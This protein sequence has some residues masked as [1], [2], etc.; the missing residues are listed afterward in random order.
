M[1][2]K[3]TS[4]WEIIYLNE[5]YKFSIGYFFRRFIFHV[6]ILK[7]HYWKSK[8]QFFNN[9]MWNT[10]KSKNAKLFIWKHL[11]FLSHT[12]SDKIYT[13]K[14]FVSIFTIVFFNVGKY[15]SLWEFLLVKIL[16]FIIMIC[17]SS[18]VHSKFYYSLY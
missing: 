1:T 8:I 4:K 15:V 2:Y 12:V 6:L 9:N 3:I 13:K 5:V 16:N 11:Q 17:N 7:N 10:K 18:I 14:L